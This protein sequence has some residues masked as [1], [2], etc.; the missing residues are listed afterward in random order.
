MQDAAKNSKDER[1]MKND[2]Q[3]L[4]ANT[5]GDTLG[6]SKAQ[7]GRKGKHMNQS[8]LAQ[9]AQLKYDKFNNLSASADQEKSIHEASNSKG[10]S[11]HRRTSS[12]MDPL[13]PQDSVKTFMN[14]KL[15]NI[16][17]FAN[18][19]GYIEGVSINVQNF[20]YDGPLG[21]ARKESFE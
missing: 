10:D 3:I 16:D 1:T 4:Q 19:L 7:S 11:S 18:K 9:M 17:R 12:M 6:T 14:E 5:E 13:F 15:K 8:K 21:L 20:D 2:I